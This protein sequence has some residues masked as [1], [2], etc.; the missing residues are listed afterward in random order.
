[1]PYLLLL[2]ERTET[3]S[4]A[5]DSIGRQYFSLREDGQ[6]DTAHS[7]RVNKISPFAVLCEARKVF[8]LLP[9]MSSLRLS[10]RALHASSKVRAALSAER[11]ADSFTGWK[12]TATDGNASKLYIDGQFVESTAKTFINI[13]DPSTQRLLTKI[14]NTTQQE[15]RRTVDSAHEAYLKWRDSSVLTRQKIM[16]K[17]VACCSVC[18]LECVSFRDPLRPAWR[19][20][21]AR[22]WTFW[23]NLLCKPAFDWR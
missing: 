5:W 6:A 22:T 19:T 18:L 8:P 11:E 23:P 13:N 4:L 15:M 12:G 2:V 17:S 20:L 21:S 10:R 16:I 3:L 9:A 7:T 14:P 1:M